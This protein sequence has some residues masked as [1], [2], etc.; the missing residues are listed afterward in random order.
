LFGSRG[1]TATTHSTWRAPGSSGETLDACG[2]GGRA[3]GSAGARRCAARRAA[4][5]RPRRAGD[6][7]RRGGRPCSIKQLYT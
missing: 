1:L 7:A 4:S 6:R 2:R 3:A 5:W